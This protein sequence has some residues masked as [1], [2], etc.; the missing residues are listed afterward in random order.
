MQDG[1]WEQLEQNCPI[2]DKKWDKEALYEY[3]VWS[4]NANYHQRLK[5]FFGGY[6]K[7]EE[8]AGLLFDFLLDD[9]YDGS[10]CQI[11]AAYYI[12]GLDREILK[13][14]QQLLLQAQENAVLWKRPFQD[15]SYLEWLQT[16]GDKIR[17]TEI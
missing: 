10:D 7:D 5:Y 15:R 17:I 11:S 13:R 4:C 3:L 12:S 9:E 14:K 1:V 16:P 6:R 8:L 2:K